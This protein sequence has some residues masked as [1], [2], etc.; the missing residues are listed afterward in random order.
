MNRPIGLKVYSFLFGLM[1]V[2]I[3]ISTLFYFIL[4][5][6]YLE[7]RMLKSFDSWYFE[8]QEDY[9]CKQAS[10]DKRASANCV[11]LADKFWNY[12]LEK[13]KKRMR[14]G[15]AMF[16]PVIILGLKKNWIFEDFTSFKLAPNCAY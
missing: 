7:P 4:Q 14:Q 5:D 12:S 3:P 10:G 6:T 15:F 13:N 1:D 16:Q 2:S 9:G 11:D 8:M